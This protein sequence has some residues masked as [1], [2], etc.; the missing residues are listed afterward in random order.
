MDTSMVKGFV[1]GGIA[2]VVLGAGGVTGYRTLATPS[3]AEVVAVKE[4]T[5]KVVTPREHCEDVR[6]QRQAPVQ[7]GHRIAGTAIGGI[8]GGLLGSTI[9]GGGAR[10]WPRSPARPPGATPATRCRK[11][12][13]RRTS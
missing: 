4:V 5:E 2:M 11:T 8:A 1:I 3:V 7:D 6:A 13:S 12:C 10:P 9:G